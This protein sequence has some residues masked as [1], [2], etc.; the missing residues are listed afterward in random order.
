MVESEDNKNNEVFSVRQF[1]NNLT[2]NSLTSSKDPFADTPLLLRPN[3]CNEFLIHD[4]AGMQKLI[5]D[6]IEGGARR[7]QTPLTARVNKG[8]IDFPKLKKI[9]YIAV[10]KPNRRGR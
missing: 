3:F 1:Y 8:K 2:I 10:R 9:P 5:F 4:R 7:R 6:E